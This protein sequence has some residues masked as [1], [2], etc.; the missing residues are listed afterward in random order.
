MKS[1]VTVMWLKIRWLLTNFMWEFWWQNLLENGH[2]EDWEGDG[3]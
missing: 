1:I 3:G 2:M